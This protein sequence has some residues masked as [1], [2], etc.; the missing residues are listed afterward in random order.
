[1]MPRQPPPGARWRI[2]ANGNAEQISLRSRDYE[3]NTGGHPE[4]TIF[5]ELV[6]DH[7]LHLEQMDRNAWWLMVG[8]MRIWITVGRDGKAKRI[9]IEEYGETPP[10]R[11]P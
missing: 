9:T 6:V 3:A 4:R 11:K 7:W 1:M 5:D 8:E 2:L 10:V